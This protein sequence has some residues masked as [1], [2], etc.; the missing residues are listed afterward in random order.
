MDMNNIQERLMEQY[1]EVTFKNNYFF[2]EKALADFSLDDIY[3]LSQLNNEIAWNLSMNLY[4]YGGSKL[5][6]EILKYLVKN[7]ISYFYCDDNEIYR[8]SNLLKEYEKVFSSRSFSID[9]LREKIFMNEKNNVDKDFYYFDIHYLDVIIMIRKMYQEKSLDMNELKKF[10][11]FQGIL[12]KKDIVNFVENYD[13]KYEYC[14]NEAISYLISGKISLDSYYDIMNCQNKVCNLLIN[15]KFGDVDKKDLTLDVVDAISSKKINQISR[16]ILEKNLRGFNHKELMNILIKMSALLGEDNVDN[17]I[18]HLPDDERMIQELLFSFEAVDISK[19]KVENRKIVY[20]QDFITFFMG[21]NLEEPTSLLNLI[22]NGKTNMGSH[23]ETLYYSF[24]NLSKRYMK[25]NLL[26]KTAFFEKTLEEST[27]FFNPDE[28]KLEG[29]IIDSY[30]DNKKHQS[31]SSFEFVKGVRD[32]YAEM[33]HDYQ[34]TIPYVS[35]KMGEYFYETLKANDPSVLTKGAETDCCFK[36]GGQ[37]DSFVRY[38]ATSKNGRVVAIKDSHGNVVAMVP[39]IRNGN[40]IICNSIESKRIGDNFFMSDMFE[41]LEHIG[42]EMIEISNKNEDDHQKI[43]A[44]LCGNYKNE[45][46][47]FRKYSPVN[48]GNAFYKI[49]PLDDKGNVSCNLGIDSHGCYCISS[50][51]EFDFNQAIVFDPTYVYDDPR[52]RTYEL[53]RD[54]IDEELLPIIQQKVD[55]ISFE[56][57]SPSVDVDKTNTVIFNEDW[58]VIVDKNNQIYASIVGNDARALEEYQEYLALEQEYCQYYD[59]Y[60]IFNQESRG[61]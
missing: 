41:I 10:I 26:T 42:Q 38:C 37:A 22:Y 9:D 40:L 6:K 49:E 60:G 12:L 39:M 7:D 35:G 5:N 8:S 18:R 61:R 50:C 4:S 31:L 53:E 36:I 44:L 46:H 43:Q 28:Y 11:E 20:N 51:D 45:I 47:K 29:Y 55:A 27:V 13:S 19:V 34:K 24:D 48:V 59:Q 56:S 58:Y 17:I 1:P 30:F 57:G 3:K 25:Q 16:R 23:L 33:K 54:Y 2:K 15:G 21:N 14:I 52:N 32:V